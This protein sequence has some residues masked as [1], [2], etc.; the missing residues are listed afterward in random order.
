MVKQITGN[1]VFS[2]I[3]PLIDNE[4]VITDCKQ[5]ATIMIKY[6]CSQARLP[7]NSGTHLLPPKVMKTT[8]RLT[9]LKFTTPEVLKVL[10]SLNPGKATGP[11]NIG[12]LMLKQSAHAI[13]ESLCRIFNYSL[14]TG[15]FPSSWKNSNVVPILKKNDHQDKT[16]YRPISLM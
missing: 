12:N 16:N 14:E 13:A 9:D 3:P 8:D 11:D 1:K 4:S 10:L 7:P 6:F 2:A 15:S 5:K